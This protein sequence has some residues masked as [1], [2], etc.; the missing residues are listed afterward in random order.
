MSG[1]RVFDFADRQEEQRRLLMS[2]DGACDSFAMMMSISFKG[3]LEED[4]EIHLCSLIK[5]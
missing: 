4:L 5:V 1:E 3:D 2:H